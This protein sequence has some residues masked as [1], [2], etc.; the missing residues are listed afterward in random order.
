VLAVLGWSERSIRSFAREGRVGWRAGGVWPRE[1]AEDRD[2]GRA[3]PAGEGQALRMR[4]RKRRA[5]LAARREPR[6]VA[7]RL[8]LRY[9]VR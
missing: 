4:S 5:G 2:G 8:P 1:P 9:V 7:T 3:R 6:D